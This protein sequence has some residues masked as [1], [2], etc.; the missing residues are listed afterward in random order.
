MPDSHTHKEIAP[1]IWKFGLPT[2][3]PIG[4]VNVYLINDS[5]KTLIDTGVNTPESQKVL[6]DHL[7]RVGVPVTALD[8]VII[9]HLHVDHYGAANWLQQQSGAELSIFHGAKPWLENFDSRRAR[10]RQWYGELYWRC[11]YGDAAIDLVEHYERSVGCYAAAARVDC[12]LFE[13]DLIPTDDDVWRVIHTPGHQQDHICLYAQRQQLLLAA[14]HLLEYITPNPCMEPP[15]RDGEPKPESLLDYR[16]SLRRLTSLDATLVLPGHGRCF[17]NLPRRLE[18]ILRHGERRNRGLLTHIDEQPKTLK[19]IADAFFG[20]HPPFDAYLVVSE[21]IG[22]LEWLL[23]QEQ[24]V[25]REENGLDL[26]QR[27]PKSGHST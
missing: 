16:R 13:G 1:G 3:F 24:I 21:I 12:V 19:A 17:E 23:D 7:A 8:R 22:H 26:Y 11:G 6:L 4:D 27:V 18:Q 25:R 10:D 14:D 15:R 20:P 2:P 9:S 5:R